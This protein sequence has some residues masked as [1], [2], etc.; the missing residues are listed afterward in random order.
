MSGKHII[1]TLIILA[2]LGTNVS[3]D[4]I[5]KHLVRQSVGEFEQISVI[6]NY[7]TLMKVENTGAFLSVG[8]TLPQP[9]KFIILSLLPVIVLALAFMFVLTQKKLSRLSVLAICFVVGGGIGNIYD[10]LVHGS[11]TDF[12]HIDFVIFETGVFNMADVSVMMGM[13]FIIIDSYIKRKATEP[14]AA[15]E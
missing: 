6:K 5:S 3:C 1:R 11:V 9:F 8:S 10:R 12:L 2:I 14:S 13:A 7:V 4:Q 15:N